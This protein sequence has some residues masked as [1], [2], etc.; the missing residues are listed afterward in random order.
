[1]LVYARNVR[2]VLLLPIHRMHVFEHAVSP[3][4]C[5]HGAYTYDNIR[6]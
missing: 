5:T 2:S 1:M 6:T 3:V 4:P